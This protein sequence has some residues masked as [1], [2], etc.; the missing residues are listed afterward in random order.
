MVIGHEVASGKCWRPLTSPWRGFRQIPGVLKA[1]QAAACKQSRALQNPG[2]RY[3][4]RAALSRRRV[5]GPLSTVP[6]LL[7]GRKVNGIWGNALGRPGRGK[8]R[9]EWGQPR[10]GGRAPSFQQTLNA[11]A[12]AA[13]QAMG[14]RPRKG[15]FLNHTGRRVC[16]AWVTAS[17]PWGPL[18]AVGFVGQMRQVP[19]KPP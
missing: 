3:P 12:S 18:E 8:R 13:T 16:T 19:V 5:V 10:G 17:L 15:M 11:R 14:H 7:L 6:S 2:K 4:Q 1:Q 9:G